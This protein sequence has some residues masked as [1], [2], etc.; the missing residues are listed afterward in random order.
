VR[1]VVER[2]LTKAG[3]RIQYFASLAEAKAALAPG[4]TLA[5]SG[6]IIDEAHDIHTAQDAWQQISNQQGM[7]GRGWALLLADQ[8][9]H[10]RYT[11]FDKALTKPFLPDDMER[12]LG[13]LIHRNNSELAAA[14][15][16]IQPRSDG[17]YNPFGPDVS[18]KVRFDGKRCLVVDDN[19]INQ[20]VIS[21]LMETFGFTIFTASDGKKALTAA[22]EH[23]CD[24]IMM[25]CRMPNM[26]GYDATRQLRA[27]MRA[28][29]LP[30]IP[31]VALTANAMKGDSEK[32]MEAGM[33]AF[34]SKPVRLPELVDVLVCLLPMSDAAAPSG[35]VVWL[36]NDGKDSA[37]E[38]REMLETMMA[39]EAPQPLPMAAPQPTYAP[40]PVAQLPA[41]APV[42]PPPIAPVAVP[43]PVAAI[44]QPFAQPAMANPPIAQPPVMQAPIAPPPVAQPPAN[45]PPFAQSPL[46]P[47]PAPIAA[48]PVASLAQIMAQ[49]ASPIMTD[50]APPLPGQTYAPPPPVAPPPCR[51]RT[52][53]GCSSP[54]RRFRLPTAPSSSAAPARSLAHRVALR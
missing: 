24:I 5:L 39:W 11:A 23:P 48:P 3:L 46:V 34:L 7:L 6:L 14:T 25:D 9:A 43:Q 38:Q 10:Y 29:H 15:P 27:M 31:I 33:D 18:A 30:S 54:P 41:A 17:P 16:A 52:P 42:A 13:V 4:N 19:S 35:D 12:A 22:V 49:P 20:M 53:N 50:G 28:G 37:A 44:A 45:P 32:C 47:P 40:P 51:C 36:S 21:E 8:Q 2:I 1:Q 26:D